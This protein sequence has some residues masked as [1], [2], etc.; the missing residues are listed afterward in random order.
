MIEPSHLLQLLGPF[1]LR[2]ADGVPIG[3]TSRKGMA[4][5]A[6]LALSRSGQRSRGWLQDRLWGTRSQDQASASLRREIHNLRT[7]LADAGLCDLVVADAHQVR[8]DLRQITV[9]LRT[10]DEDL[11]AGR[12]CAVLG[13]GELLEGLDLPGE[14]GFE[15]WLREQRSLAANL[16]EQVRTA[17]WRRDALNPGR[18]EPVLVPTDLAQRSDPPMP[19]KPSISVLPFELLRGPPHLATAFS[20]EITLTLSRWSTLF[21]VAAGPPRP[22]PVPRSQICRELGVRYLLEG[23][24]QE[25]GELIR[26]QVRLID[27]AMGEQLWAD[28]FEAAAGAVFAL[29]DRIAR[30]V[31][32]LIESTLE[33]TERRTVAALP[34]RAAGAHDLYWEANA[35]IRLWERDATRRAIDL[36]GRVL[37]IEPDNGWAA[38]LIAFGHAVLLVQNW[39]DDPTATLRSATLFVE[40]AMRI[41]S[42]DPYVI[43]Q[44]AAAMVGI[45][46][47]LTTAE[48][49][50]ERALAMNPNMPSTLFWSG[51]VDV[52]QGRPE[53]AI[54]RF[55]FALRLNPR[56][57]VRP[58][59]LCGTAL[60]LLHLGRYAEAAPLLAEASVQLPHFAPAQLAAACWA[61]QLGQAAEAAQALARLAEAGG[62]EAAFRILRHPAQQ[63]RI[64]TLLAHASV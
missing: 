3:I 61:L 21:V 56:M 43:S 24:V 39:T 41:G 51:W 15:D 60:A 26:V 57:A 45:G 8:L 2:R 36:A 25:E 22:H 7:M 18:A 31:A 35:L 16:V 5:I 64:R 47:D 29:Q 23:S 30:S 13:Y 37:D 42:D 59:V 33:K 9:D 1:D 34:V 49:L 58:Y 48:A 6:L 27:G 55:L 20:D 38:S 53:R 52:A 50:I 40:R 63:A 11:A 62:V 4:L 12:P 10:L 14:E 54:E 19:V 46:G 17:A 28:R 32:P 44:V